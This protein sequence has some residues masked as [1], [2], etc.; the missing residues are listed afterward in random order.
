MCNNRPDK[1]RG[2]TIRLRHW[3][4]R[5]LAAE[6]S[7]THQF[8]ETHSNFGL[9]PVVPEGS[10][11]GSG[12]WCTAAAGKITST[13]EMPNKGASKSTEVRG[14]RLE[15]AYTTP[16]CSVAFRIHT[17]STHFAVDSRRERPSC[18]LDPT[19]LERRLTR[20]VIELLVEEH[21][22]SRCS[23]HG[24]LSS[25]TSNSCLDILHCIV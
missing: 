1:E 22:H 13:S 7:L 2:R 3:I 17:V 23:G 15:H 6:Q 5:R 20:R 25:W 18:S 21:L 11:L 12:N 10:C 19:F 16:C 9:L 14:E 4:R 24:A 8:P